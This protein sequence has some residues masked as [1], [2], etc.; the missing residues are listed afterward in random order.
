ME[1]IGL[2]E[3]KQRASEILR[4]V[5]EQRETFAIT[6]RG[7]VVAKVV[8][9]DDDTAARQAEGLATWA[10]MDELTREISVYWPRDISALE[11]VREQRREL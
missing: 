8:P 9:V 3:L 4:R 1:E 10:E 2:R 11:A 7:K 6:Y 5:R